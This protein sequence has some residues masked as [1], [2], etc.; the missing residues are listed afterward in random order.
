MEFKLNETQSTIQDL[1]RDFAKNVLDKRIDDI[2]EVGHFPKDVYQQMADAGLLS[3]AFDEELG[4]IGAGY[5][6]FVLAYEELAKVSPSAAT[7]LLITLLPLEGINLFGT[8]EQKQAYIP[9]SLTGSYRG[10]MAFTEAG[11]GSDPKQLTT[12]ARLE[13]DTWVIS[14]VKRFISNAAYPGPML[15]YANEAETGACTAFLFDKFEGEQFVKGYSLSTP[16]E[17]I[18]LLGS[19]CYDIFLDEVRVPNDAMHI[20]G[21]RGDGF[22]I[23][24]ATTAYGKLGFSAVFTG[25]LGGAVDAA[26]QYVTTKVH[27]SGTITK[28]QAIQM[29]YATLLAKY[30]SCRLMVSDCAEVA[31][32]HTRLGEMLGK[33]ALVKAY[34]GDTAVEGCVLAMNLMGSYGVMKEYQVERFLRDALIG[35]HVEGQTDVQRVIA[36]SYYLNQ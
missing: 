21:Q 35:P 5:D 19:P 22:K 6:S 36:A 25:A 4:G 31:N 28:F 3:I 27:R 2:E 14:G 30:D 8:P 18:G 9:A 15:L 32:D 16:W 26:K 33:S 13:G 23:L 34:V 11:T 1:A 20:L 12:V 7:A 10:S 17:K 29:K 24:K